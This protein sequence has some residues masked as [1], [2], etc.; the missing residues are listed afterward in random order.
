[1][2]TDDLFLFD[3]LEEQDFPRK[4]KTSL[5]IFFASSPHECISDVYNLRAVI[6]ESS[7]L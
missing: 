6:T 5:K 4:R 3:G 1:M 7:K 2:G